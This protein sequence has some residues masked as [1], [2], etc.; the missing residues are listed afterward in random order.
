MAADEQQQAQ[1]DSTAEDLG[2]IRSESEQ[3]TDQELSPAAEEELAGL[4][5]EIGRRFDV[6]FC[7]MTFNDEKVYQ[8]LDV[9]NMTQY[10]DRLVQTKALRNPLKDLPLWAKIWPGSFVLE[11]YLR[12]KVACEGRT[13]LE[14]GAGCGVLAILA[15]RLGF[16]H[17]ITSDVEDMALR[18]AKAN[19]LKNNLQEQIEVRHIDVTRPGT[20]PGLSTSLDVIAAS[21]ILYLD[22]LHGPILNF[23]D[24]HLAADGL[25]VFCTDVARRKPHF[26]RKAAKRFLVNEVYLPGSFSGTDGEQHKRIFSL[27]TLQKHA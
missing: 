17:I 2:V 9:S 3:K 7:P 24:R 14:L 25:A 13:M 16:A 12:K 11:T 15:S 18:F 8:I 22:E 20:C 19:V 6:A 10:L 23:L 1:G 26:A 5:E 27:L 21:E 4:L